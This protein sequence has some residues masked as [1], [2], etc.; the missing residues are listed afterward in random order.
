MPV[1]NVLRKVLWRY[2]ERRLEFSDIGKLFISDN[3]IPLSSRA[4]EKAIKEYGVQA[5][6]SG[7]RVSPHTFHHTF[8][9]NH[10]L[11]GGD[12]FSLQQILGHTTMDMVRQ[13][14][15]LAGRDV[16][17]Q[18]QKFSPGDRFVRGARI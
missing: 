13:Y 16:K 11:N 3:G 7:V 17:E 18:H 15:N 1:G 4:V 10:I 9:K 6:I 5:K 14:V 8:A 12:V 2:Q